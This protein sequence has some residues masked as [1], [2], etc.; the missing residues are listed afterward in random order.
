MF[1][2]GIAAVLSLFLL[3]S[4][5]APQPK[6]ADADLF[7]AITE[8]LRTHIDVNEE[9]TKDLVIKLLQLDADKTVDAYAAFEGGESL[10]AAIVIE[11]ADEE[12]ALEASESLQYYRSTLQNLASQYSPDQAALVDDAYIHTSG[13]MS[14]LVISED[15][16]QI[17]S[18]LADVL[19]H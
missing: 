6:A 5:A 19:P 12:S 10:K 16:P 17:K 7:H 4:C 14:I 3:C 9:N 2:K 13:V 1:Q 11:S 8:T 18:E 15:I